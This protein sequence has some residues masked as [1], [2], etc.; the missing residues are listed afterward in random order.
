MEDDQ[1]I[2]LPM[3]LSGDSADGDGPPGFYNNFFTNTISLQFLDTS[4]DK[5]KQKTSTKKSDETKTEGR[6]GSKQ[7]PSLVLGACHRCRRM[8][9]KCDKMRCFVTNNECTYDAV[10]PL[11]KPETKAIVN[12]VRELESMMRLL[13]EQINNMSDEDED[14]SDEE[15]NEATN[16]RPHM[17]HRYV[18][19]NQKFQD[20]VGNDVQG[21]KPKRTSAFAEEDMV[22]DDDDNVWMKMNFEINS[23]DNNSVTEGRVIP[24]PAQPKKRWNL[25]IT[26][27]GINIDSNATSIAEILTLLMKSMDS[28]YPSPESSLMQFSNRYQE[29]MRDADDS[30][31]TAIAK[32]SYGGQ[33]IR[34]WY[35][36]GEGFTLRFQTVLL[37]PVNFKPD[38]PGFDYPMFTA[39]MLVGHTIDIYLACFYHFKPMFPNDKFINYV[40]DYITPSS[41]RPQ[42]PASVVML[43]YAICPSI[44]SHTFKFH[45]SH[46][47][48][49]GHTLNLQPM[50]SDTS[51][52]VVDD[53]VIFGE[54]FYSQARDMLT[55]LFDTEDLWVA[56]ALHHMAIYC[57]H[58]SRERALR[59]HDMSIRVAIALGANTKEGVYGDMYDKEFGKRLWWAICKY[60]HMISFVGYSDQP[61]VVRQID[62]PEP[63]PMEREDAKAR[64]AIEATNIIYRFSFLMD[65]ISKV[66]NNMDMTALSDRCLRRL[67]EIETS[68]P[69]YLRYDDALPS[70]ATPQANPTPAGPRDDPSLHHDLETFQSAFALYIRL[71]YHLCIITMNRH[72]LTTYPRQDDPSGLEAWTICVNSAYRLVELFEKIYVVNSSRLCFDDAYD[73]WYSCTLSMVTD[74][75]L[76]DAKVGSPVDS[77][78]QTPLLNMLRDPASVDDAIFSPGSPNAPIHSLFRTSSFAERKPSI[79][80]LTSPTRALS[81]RYLKRVLNVFRSGALQK[82]TLYG[83]MSYG[84]YVYGVLSDIQ[85]Y[86]ALGFSVFLATH[87]TQVALANVGVDVANNWLL[88]GRPLYQDRLIENVVVIGGVTAHVAAGVAKACMRRPK[89][90][91]VDLEGDLTRYAVVESD[92]ALRLAEEGRV[93]TVISQGAR[94]RIS[95]L[96]P[97]HRVIGYMLIPVLLGHYIITRAAPLRYF[98]D[99][100]FL[101]FSYISLGLQTHPRL[102]GGLQV[103]LV[104]LGM[105]HVCSGT[106]TIW[107]R[108]FGGRSRATSSIKHSYRPLHGDAK[109]I[110]M[111]SNNTGTADSHS[112]TSR[113]ISFGTSQATAP[114][115]LPASSTGSVVKELSLDTSDNIH[116]PDW[117]RP[118]DTKTDVNDSNVDVYG[119]GRRPS[120]MDQQSIAGSDH[121]EIVPFDSAPHSALNMSKQ[122]RLPDSTPALPPSPGMPRGKKEKKGLFPFRRKKSKDKEEDDHYREIPRSF[123]RKLSDDAASP[124]SS[125]DSPANSI[126][127]PPSSSTP[128]PG[129]RKL[130]KAYTSSA[131]PSQ[132]QINNYMYY[133]YYRAPLSS[134][135]VQPSGRGRFFRHDFLDNRSPKSPLA[136]DTDF[137]H[138]EGI[139]NSNADLHLDESSANR[140]LSYSFF[141]DSSS[142]LVD[143]TSKR[144]DRVASESSFM[145]LSQ[146]QEHQKRLHESAQ[147]S[148]RAANEVD[149]TS[150]SQQT[151]SLPVP[152]HGTAAWAPPESW[153]V[154]PVGYLGPL[155]PAELR[156]ESQ[157]SEIEESKFDYNLNMQDYTIR[158][159]R[160]DTTFTVLSCP[161][162]TSTADIIQMLAKK[163]FLQDTTRYNLYIKYHETERALMPTERPLLMQKTLLEQMGYTDLDRL[164]DLGREDNSYLVRFTFRPAAARTVPTEEEVDFGNY[165]HVDLQ[166][167]NLR[168]IPIFLYNQANVIVSLN[169]SR[170]WFIALPMDF[171]QLCSSLRELTLCFNDFSQIPASIR[172]IATLERLNIANNKVKELDHAHLEELPNLRSLEVSNNQL[173]DLPKGFANMKNLRFLSIANNYFTEFPKI[174]CEIPSLEDL[175]ISFNKI[176]S[177]PDE[178]SKME[179]L[180]SFRAVANELAGEL[181]ASWSE[182]EHLREVDIRQNAITSLTT[183]S[184]VLSLQKLT[185]DYNAVSVVQTEFPNLCTLKASKNHL[186]QFKLSPNVPSIAGFPS[187]TG[188]VLTNL[189]LSGCKLSTLSDELLATATAIEVLILDNNFLTAI[190]KTISHL[191][192]L[193]K[194]S[195]QNNELADIPFEIS[196]LADLRILDLQQNN[197]KTLP[198]EIWLCP[199]LQSLNC[200]SNLLTAFPKPIS[201][202]GVQLSTTGGFAEYQTTIPTEAFPEPVMGTNSGQGIVDMETVTPETEAA[203]KI[204]SFLT[205]NPPSFFSS[206]RNHPPPVTLTLRNLALGDNRFTDEVFGP[207]SLFSELR[208][209]NLSFNDMYEIPPEGLCHHHLHELYLSGNHLSSLPADDIEKLS[210]LRV[211]HLNG[212][213]LQTLPA[214]LGKL[215][216]LQVLDVGS[217]MLKYN[218]AN[219]PYDWNW[220]WNLALKY[221]NFSG[222][223]RFEIKQSHNDLNGPRDR[224]LSDFSALRKLRVLGLMDVTILVSPPDEAID[225]R[226][227]TSPSEVNN[228][229]YGIADWLG[230]D[231]RLTSWD[232]VIPRFR[233]R[234]DECLFGLFDS[235]S[236]V[237]DG[238][239]VNAFLNTYL[240]SHLHTEL[241]KLKHDETVV[242]ALRRTFLGLERDLGFSDIASINVGASA[243]VCYIAGKTLYAANIGDALAVLSRDGGSAVEISQKHIALNP[244]ETSRIRQAGG[245]VSTTGLLNDELAVS[246]NFGHFHLNPVLN[247]NPYISAIELSEQDEF[248]ILANRGLWDRVSYQQAVD[249]CVSEKDDLLFAAQKLRDFAI[250]YGADDSIMVMVIGVGD[251]FD[252]NNRRLRTSR[253]GSGGNRI[254]FGNEISMDEMNCGLVLS[255]KVRRGKDEMPGDSTL[256]RLPREVAPPIGQVAICFTD[257]KNSTFLWETQPI[258]MRSAIK[259]H[260]SLLRR[261][262]RSVG[263]YE[264]KTEGDAFMV[265]FSSVTSALLWCFTVQLQL[266]EA[267][268]PTEILES[269][270]GRP[271]VVDG[272]VLYRGLSVRMGVHWGSPV[273]E[274]DPITKRMD[275]FGPV[276]NRASRVCSAADGGQICVSSDVIM[277]LKKHHGLYEKT[278][279]DVGDDISGRT[280]R[281]VLS[282][283]KLGFSVREIGERKL[284]GLETAEMLSM[285]L[286]KQLTQRWEL[287][288][289]KFVASVSNTSGLIAPAS[290]AEHSIKVDQHPH[291][292]DAALVRT[293]GRLC[294]R[295]EYLASGQARN[296]SSQNL[297]YL[298]SLMDTHVRDDADEEDL[299]RILENVVTRIENATSSLYLS[300]MGGFADVLEKLS[301]AVELDPTYLLKALQIYVQTLS[302]PIIA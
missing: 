167:R 23:N 132:P 121:S 243:V 61:S 128:E 293:V 92:E 242:A 255:K 141:K 221:L 201:A 149:K 108:V 34:F 174:L 252:S 65:D 109:E 77:P 154:Q 143:P 142:F 152:A 122:E 62:I 207:L 15:M 100:A 262:L 158:I 139:V 28:L 69:I 31:E 80:H 49:H 95:M 133:M 13:Q 202:V 246:R 47:Y 14:G 284:K 136:I 256:A 267:D 12:K 151:L 208:S 215:R 20:T 29:D 148:M 162:S 177:L 53:S 244:S 79:T 71:W 140:V 226:I 213:K 277:S 217:N 261:Q 181:P 180:R 171:V 7:G 93:N 4:H 83:Q 219:W 238:N 300:R 110:S 51:K 270:D 179:S 166:L 230:F 280:A 160:P 38:N 117:T 172:Y 169:V 37:Q 40:Q 298:I 185:C 145:D 134:S 125:L 44:A 247:A 18:D 292:I 231:D 144:M 281:D 118:H 127:L 1:G 102:F 288:K 248:V 63:V 94:K 114:L 159:F 85:A 268:W 97:G 78:S 25:N 39:Q 27:S 16:A 196:H 224:N 257:I 296:G 184:A 111:D 5:K 182:L 68:I 236:G 302:E 289:S 137:E 150:V 301:T 203:T 35:L 245:Y 64:L 189:N 259:T 116:E 271:I 106:A 157:D 113:T 82:R 175:D 204:D 105:Y 212:N 216:K 45:Q 76:R 283:R 220:N 193:G 191:H 120:I 170:N 50:Q 276:V 138:M 249:I 84:R 200:S 222:N 67:E 66:S 241:R 6:K 9:R 235:K 21:S 165:E 229:A 46:L 89:Y 239:P 19:M 161:L 294:L 183:L 218:I 282:L 278:V 228:L 57:L 211:L 199:A 70:P 205:F 206:P 130:N 74:V 269:E 24:S 188:S 11:K 155:G 195:V 290:E 264:V 285:V 8:K 186:T 287:D 163:Y 60:S 273:W 32:R 58:R 266:L 54:W 153:A 291:R 91:V 30:E 112:A 87:A 22:D 214:E 73:A 119:V 56:T 90:Q 299:Y 209:L 3:D 81:A 190:P 88:L 237:K 225:R 197:L 33:P 131:A 232:L 75:L 286:P 99:S 275:Y 126:R 164:E 297:K 59:Y 147:K 272:H 52:S 250:T 233:G 104:G 279:D 176:S 123:P 17:T 168:T 227:R 86:S 41:N 253:G 258:A 274:I 101:D 124:T 295:L 96:L 265:C 55:E 173:K 48:S 72:I 210:H 129:K 146:L 36:H 254:A 260:N 198:K 240:S 103:A 156:K 194:L 10:S 43:M 135:S 251:I 115:H 187:L 107:K 2:Q 98:G 178:S 42:P 263:G 234:D 26:P 223:K 192:K